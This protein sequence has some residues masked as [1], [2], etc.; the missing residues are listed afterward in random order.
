MEFKDVKP[1]TVFYHQ[2]KTTLRKLMEVA[3]REIP[4]MQEEAKKLGLEEVSPMQFRYLDC[5]SD[6]DKEFTLE[7]GMVVGEKKGN[8]EGLYDFKEW[9]PL[10][11]ASHIYKGDIRKIGEEYD[12]IFPEVL[13]SGREYNKEIRE[14]YTRYI[15]PDSPENIT[16][17]QIGLN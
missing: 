7:I 9:G 8:L 6:I 1:L 5:T 15:A 12:K 14:V 2:E 16:E 10:S 17:I 11:C 4:K 3:D 13:N